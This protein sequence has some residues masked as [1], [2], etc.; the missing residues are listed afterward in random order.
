MKRQP[1][2][3]AVVCCVRF[4]NDTQLEKYFR[5]IL[6]LF[7]PYRVPDDLK[8]PGCPTYEDFYRHGHWL[9]DGLPHSVKDT[10][11][12]NR[13][14]FERECQDITHSDND[15]VNNDILQD[16]WCQMCPQ[17]W[18]E[19]LECDEEMRLCVQT[20][21]EDTDDNPDFPDS[22]AQGSRFEAHALCTMC[23]TDALH[24]LRSLNVQQRDIFYQVRHW[25]NAKVNGKQ[26]RPFHVFITGGDGTGK[27]HLIKA[28]Q[29]EATRLL[30]QVASSPDKVTVL[31]T[32]PTGIA[33]YSIQATTIHSTL[34]IGMNVKPYMPLGEAKLS[35]L[36]TELNDLQILVIDEI[37][38]VSHNLLAYIHGRLRQVMQSGDHS[39]FGNVCHSCGRLFPAQPSSSQGL[40]FDRTTM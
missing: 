25:C 4:S 27:T 28:L 10:V 14:T 5:N 33:A 21:D 9:L 8:P 38:M 24:L 34:S 32:A 13:L 3:T 40:V 35:T 36:R 18:L 22:G 17:Q 2:H 39:P 26:P 1:A 7:L 15:V 20:V 11:D 6:Q 37:S 29:Y 31:L 19:D 30:S 23:R 12:V 16:A